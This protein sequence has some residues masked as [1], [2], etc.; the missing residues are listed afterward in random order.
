M[1]VASMILVIS[2]ALFFFYVQAT[3]QKILARKFS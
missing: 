1:I 2:V 3:C